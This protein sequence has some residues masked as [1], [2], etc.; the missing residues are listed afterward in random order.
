MDREQARRKS[1]EDAELGLEPG[2]VGA[3][4]N[5]TCVPLWKRAQTATEVADE[6][7]DDRNA[8]TSSTNQPPLRPL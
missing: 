5:R 7:A 2:L 8:I 4:N 3:P 6:D 1:G